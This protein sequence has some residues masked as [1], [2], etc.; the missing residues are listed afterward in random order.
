MGKDTPV[1][2]C[3]QMMQQKTEHQIIET[4]MQTE[5]TTQQLMQGEQPTQQYEHRQQNRYATK[6]IQRLHASRMRHVVQLTPIQQ[7]AEISPDPYIN[8]SARE[9]KKAMQREERARKANQNAARKKQH[10]AARM[11]PIPPQ[12]VAPDMLN[13]MEQAKAF[14]S[15]QKTQMGQPLDLVAVSQMK[16]DHTCLEDR[17]FVNTGKTIDLIKALQQH[18]TLK[19]L[20][21]FR[22]QH[23]DQWNELDNEM[24]ARC[25]LLLDQFPA[26]DKYLTCACNLRNLNINYDDNGAMRGVR[27]FNFSGTYRKFEKQHRCMRDILEARQMTEASDLE[28]YRTRESHQLT[29]EE[30][31]ACIA[32]EKEAYRAKF[33][34]EQPLMKDMSTS[35]RTTMKNEYRRVPAANKESVTRVSK[36]FFAYANQREKSSWPDIVQKQLSTRDIMIARGA[37]NVEMFSDSSFLNA[38]L[39]QAAQMLDDIETL[40]KM[41]KTKDITNANYEQV[42]DRVYQHF[43]LCF[44]R[45]HT[46]F[47]QVRAQ[48]KTA[49]TPEGLMVQQ[50]EIGRF[51]S[52]WQALMEVYG[53]SPSLTARIPEEQLLYLR[54][55]SLVISGYPSTC[56]DGDFTQNTVSV[57]DDLCFRGDLSINT[58]EIEDMARSNAFISIHTSLEDC[59]PDSLTYRRAVQYAESMGIRSEVAYQVLRHM[60]YQEEDET[61]AEQYRMTKDTAKDIAATKP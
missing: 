35:E 13:L 4:Q 33:G 3:E 51:Y 8:M 22:E 41:D 47:E 5:Q 16:L 11:F 58:N 48:L 30:R 60:G 37:Q 36:A 25:S 15:N 39:E 34:V 28:Y 42:L 38:E 54:G 27:Y 10:S 20:W 12:E 7:T 40:C 32:Q 18:D 53:Q 49:L 2:A 31:D 59:P 1:T 29:I 50:S 61:F 14:F 44:E 52:Y 21:D 46:D 56:L 43:E 23:R 6:S 57:G 19:K 55:I 45:F 24:R 26:F 9:R 17:D